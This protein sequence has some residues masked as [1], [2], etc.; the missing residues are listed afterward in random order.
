MRSEFC[1]IEINKAPNLEIL[2]IRKALAE[3]VG[4]KILRKLKS[5]TAVVPN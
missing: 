5:Y 2:T 3:A 1:D 4:I